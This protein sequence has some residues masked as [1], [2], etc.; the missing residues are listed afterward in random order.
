[1]IEQPELAARIIASGITLYMMLVILRWMGPALEIELDTP[2]RAWVRRLTDP[3]I[4]L[5]RRAIGQVMGP[6]DWAPVAVLFALWILRILT[7][8]F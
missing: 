3:P 6:F 1:M 7:A 4:G 8:G 2:R 5:A